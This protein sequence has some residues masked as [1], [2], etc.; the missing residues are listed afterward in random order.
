[1]TGPGEVGP[2][3]GSER[4]GADDYEMHVSPSLSVNAAMHGIGYDQKGELPKVDIG[5]S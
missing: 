5:R 2:V 3:D 4:P 1:M